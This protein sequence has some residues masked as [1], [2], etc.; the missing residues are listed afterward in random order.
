MRERVGRGGLE[1]RVG[2]GREGEREGLTMTKLIHVHVY[3]YLRIYSFDYSHVKEAGY[4]DQDVCMY[5]ASKCLVHLSALAL[6]PLLQT[7]GAPVCVCSL[8]HEQKSL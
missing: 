6:F 7:S 2:I 8:L 5:D 1:G 3:V 4:F